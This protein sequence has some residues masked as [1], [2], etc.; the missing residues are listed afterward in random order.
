[1]IKR[2]LR[3]AMLVVLAMVPAL[4][5][6]IA[7][8]PAVPPGIDP[9][10]EAIMLVGTGID[11]RNEKIAARL[12]RDGEGEIIGWDIVDADRKPFAAHD[13]VPANINATELALKLLNAHPSARIIPLRIAG[14]D[15]R[16][17]K[18]SLVK[19]VFYIRQ[20]P[21]RVVVLT[22]WRV[23]GLNWEGVR[24]AIGTLGDKLFIAAPVI[25]DLHPTWPSKLNLPNS[26]TVAPLS[27][28]TFAEGTLQIKG[29]NTDVWA[30]D[31]KVDKT[32]R[33]PVISALA[34]VAG[35]AGCLH[36]KSPDLTGAALRQEL[37]KMSPPMDG[38]SEVLLLEPN[39]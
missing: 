12:A 13:A 8:D 3:L 4:R 6:A 21:A 16:V 38:L 37:V 24:R 39:C 34:A 23:E 18:Q 20:M 17:T 2:P 10:G 22:A 15:G 9:G 33:Q 5:T 35:Q 14:E 31:E 7:A 36:K 11:Y 25:D 19:G 1:M 26:I 32:F 28:N 27:Q 30:D 29:E